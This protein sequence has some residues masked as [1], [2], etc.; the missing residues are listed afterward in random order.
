MGCG[1]RG[2]AATGVVWMRLGW[3]GWRLSWIEVWLRIGR[4]KIG[5]SAERCLQLR[6]VDTCTIASLRKPLA[7]SRCTR[8]WSRRS[9]GAPCHLGLA[10]PSDPELLKDLV[11]HPGAAPRLQ[12][13]ISKKGP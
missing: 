11:V 9:A 6:R 10:M 5:E 8:P 13:A 1:P 12:F 3:C 4:V 2:R 7:P